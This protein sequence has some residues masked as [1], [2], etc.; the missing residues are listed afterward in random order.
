MVYG[1]DILYLIGGLLMLVCIIVSVV[2][3]FGLVLDIFLTVYDFLARR[4]GQ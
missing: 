2:M 1:A 3:F 4:K